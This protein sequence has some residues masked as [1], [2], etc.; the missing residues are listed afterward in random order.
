MIY[1]VMCGRLG[2]QLFQ[3]AF[4]R[5]VQNETGQELAIDFTAINQV[6]DP[7]WRNY[8]NEYNVHGYK[9]VD[10]NEYYPIQRFLYKIFKILRPK[11]NELKQ[12]K[13]DEFIAK[14]FSGCGVIYYESDYKFHD[15]NL[16]EIKAKNIIIRGWFES[17]QYFAGLSDIL[18]RELTL[19]K[20]LSRESE[21]ISRLLRNAETICVTIRRGNFTKDKYKKKFL[22]CEPDYYYK[23]VEYIRKIHSGAT[24]YICSDDIEWCKAKLKFPGNVIFEP[25]SEVCEKLYLMSLCKHFVIGNSTFSWWAQYLSSNKE[26]IVIAPSKWRNCELPPKDIYNTSWVCLDSNGEISEER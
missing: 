1:L 21:E 12:Y 6:D 15:Y 7:E 5:K 24:V 2:N 26:K 23:G 19:K 22:I 8:L 14:K 16:S 13:F 20:A 9:T 17:E 3:Y 11:S 4:A 25:Q 10:K 18:K